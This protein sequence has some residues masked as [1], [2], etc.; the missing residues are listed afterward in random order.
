MKADG[1]LELDSERNKKFYV[2]LYRDPRPHKGRSP[3]YIGKGIS[4]NRRAESHI[5]K[6]HNPF[7]AVILAKIRAAGL[8][9]EIEIVARFDLEQDALDLEK[10]LITQYGR[11]D[12]GL[13]TL[14][15]LADGGCSG[16]TGRIVS[17]IEKERTR[18][19]GAAVWADEKARNKLLIALTAAGKRSW[20]AERDF[21]LARLADGN[22]KRREDPL[23]H[24]RF[25]EQRAAAA[26][27]QWSDPEHKKAHA[28]KNRAA[29]ILAW[30]DP[31]HRASRSIAI[32][33]G[34]EAA[35]LDPEKKQRRLA[36][37]RSI[38]ALGGIAGN[39][40]WKDPVKKAARIAKARATR[41][42][43]AQS[44]AT[45]GAV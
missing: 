28:S 18:Q 35:M 43:N 42:A 3:I 22:K 16:P 21:R 29:N 26:K 33:A 20:A 32:K 13:G 2:Y 24:G 17:E 41:R 34:I 39:A 44:K 5:G 40:A 38:A 36:H 23:R 4:A 15:N 19:M 8:K 10:K 14:V 6:T 45:R 9:P 11:R 31:S 30:S 12:L 37:V 25:V 7:F 1:K 27:K